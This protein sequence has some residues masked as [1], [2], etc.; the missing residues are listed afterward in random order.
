MVALLSASPPGGQNRLRFF[1]D[2]A[3]LICSVCDLYWPL[4]T[5]RSS[6]AAA[7]SRR[8][9]LGVIPTSGQWWRTTSCRHTRE[10]SLEFWHQ[11]VAV[12]SL[13]VSTNA[14][15]KGLETTTQ[16]AEL[17]D[18]NNFFLFLGK[19]AKKGKKNDIRQNS[20]GGLSIKDER[21]SK[22]SKD[23]TQQSRVST[24]GGAELMRRWWARR[25]NKTNPQLATR[26]S[27]RPGR[28]EE[29]EEEKK[30]GCWVTERQQIKQQLYHKHGLNKM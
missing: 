22:K 25:D 27:R 17:I 10:I 6:P 20:R 16:L 19:N 8:V 1:L 30:S 12:S 21:A 15:W 5:F 2:P 26:Q 18:T 23:K 4:L 28:Q 14:Q 13:F 3:G 11:C 9:A 24:S 7:G 29:E